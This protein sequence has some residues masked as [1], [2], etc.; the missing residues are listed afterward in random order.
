MDASDI[1]TSPRH[2]YY[3]QKDDTEAQHRLAFNRINN[4][5]HRSP[6]FSDVIAIRRARVPIIKC[7]HK[8]TGFSIDINIS[9]PSSRENTQFIY[10]LVQ[11]DDRIHE[12]MLFLKLWAKNMQ[13]IGRINMTSYCLITMAIFFLQQPWESVIQ[14]NN[15]SDNRILKSIKELQE[16]CPFH[17]VQGV[18]YAYDLSRF[19]NKPKIPA[20]VTTWDLIKEFFNFYQNFDFEH[21]IISPFY[22]KAVEKSN[23]TPDIWDEYYKQLNTIT[24]YLKGEQANNL[25]IDRSMCVQ[26]AFCLNHNTAK[27]ILPQSKQYIMLCL[28]NAH[29][30][31]NNAKKV[32]QAQLYEQL[33]FESIKINDQNIENV[34]NKPKVE[35]EAELKNL[36]LLTNETNILNNNESKLIYTLIPSK[37]DLRTAALRYPVITGGEEILRCW[38][39]NYVKAIETIIT[40]IYRMDMQKQL[41]A[42]Q[43]QQKLDEEDKNKELNPSWLISCTVDLWTS[44]CFQKNLKTSFISYQLEQT[45]RL[46]EL[47]RQDPKFSVTFNGILKLNTLANFMGLDIQLELPEGTCISS[48]NKKSP[49]RRFFNV[50][51][52]TLQSC[53][54]KET[55]NINDTNTKNINECIKQTPN[56]EAPRET[57][58]TV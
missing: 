32:N 17:M 39:Q 16:D 47:R 2:K 14:D 50:F 29:S 42:Q 52:N 23:L 13:I 4:L 9:C 54:F 31:C 12:L 3:Q 41:H 22:G 1:H 53:N 38:C 30:I 25:Q 11:S 21:N 37:S 46:H 40:K 5:L 48:L 55:L 36:K 10:D 51:K 28:R 57:L 18:N 44:R 7:K 43:K 56:C 19:E 15:D 49:L 20:A 35:V 26:D 8:D 34:K 58:I 6:H 45:E 33:L 24:Q 27:N